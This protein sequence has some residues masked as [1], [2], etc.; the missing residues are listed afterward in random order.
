MCSRSRVLLLALYSF[1]SAINSLDN[2]CSGLRGWTWQSTVPFRSGVPH[3][4]LK[5]LRGDSSTLLNP[6]GSSVRG[7]FPTRGR[8]VGKCGLPCVGK[9]SSVRDRS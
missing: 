7:S 8:V 4:D 1:P 9:G 3:R 6:E 5:A 2:L